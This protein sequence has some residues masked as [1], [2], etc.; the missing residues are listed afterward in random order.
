[1]AAAMAAMAAA[2]A[3]PAEAER[4]ETDSEAAGPLEGA[5]ASLA[6]VPEV[7]VAVTAAA[8]SPAACATR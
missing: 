3:P 1:M 2:M 6:R 8:E 4:V 7:M 5:V